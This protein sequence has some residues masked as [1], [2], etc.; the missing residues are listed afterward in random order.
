MTPQG[1]VKLLERIG[2]MKRQLEVAA[3]Y[4]QRDQLRTAHQVLDDV[5]ARVDRAMDEI[6][7]ETPE[8]VVEVR[9]A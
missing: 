4:V 9:C 6:E 3:R 7:K 1:R 2:R 5:I 8:T